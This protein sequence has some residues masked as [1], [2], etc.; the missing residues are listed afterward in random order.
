LISESY[1]EIVIVANI[2]KEKPG[3]S[4]ALKIHFSF[5]AINFHHLTAIIPEPS[6]TA[7]LLS[8]G[9]ILARHHQLD[10]F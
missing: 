8:T 5:L 9:S 2:D 6:F 7:P 4:R 10:S 3:E 1:S